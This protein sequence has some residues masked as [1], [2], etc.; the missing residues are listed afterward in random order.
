MV[1]FVPMYYGFGIVGW[2]IILSLLGWFN[3]Q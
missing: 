1:T 3:D 2:L